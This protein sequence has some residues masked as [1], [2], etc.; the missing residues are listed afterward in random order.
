VAFSFS[1]FN[2]SAHSRTVLWLLRGRSALQAG[3]SF[4]ATDFD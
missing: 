3:L 4:K 1:S 2:R